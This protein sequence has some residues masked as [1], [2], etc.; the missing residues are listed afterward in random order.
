MFY[1]SYMAIAFHILDVKQVL[2]YYN[3]IYHFGTVFGVILYAI[4]FL[5]L[6]KRKSAIKSK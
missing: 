2:H 4:G 6:Q 3:S 5:V 1:F